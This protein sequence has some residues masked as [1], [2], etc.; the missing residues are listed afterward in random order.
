M[1]FIQPKNNRC[2]L[3]CANWGGKRE[4]Y[5]NTSAKTDNVSTRG[6]CY[7]GVQA[8]A[9]PGPCASNGTYCNKYRPWGALR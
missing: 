2:C 7:E 8:D 6:K 4:V 9:T 5:I 1:S 3:T